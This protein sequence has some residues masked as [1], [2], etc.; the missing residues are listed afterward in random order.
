MFNQL[1]RW[2]FYFI[3][4]FFVITL[5]FSKDLLAQE[6]QSTSS[7][8]RPKIGLALSGGGAR[9]M[10]HVGVL[11]AL[12]KLRVPIDYIA[13]TSMG[14]I[15]GGLYASGVTVEELHRAAIE[16]INW[17]GILSTS[18]DLETLSYREKQNRRRFLL[19]LEMG[20]GRGQIT[21]PSGWIGGHTLFLELKRFTN[22]I[23]TDDFSQLP[24]PF[25]AVATDLKT[26]KPYLIEKGDLALALRASMAVPFIFSPVEM[27]GHVLVDGGILENLPVNAVKEMGAEIIIAINVSAPLSEI[28]SG[29]SFFQI[30]RQSID[31][32]LIQ[33]TRQALEHA[34]IVITPELEG[35]SSTNFTDGEKLITQGYEAVKKKKILFQNLSLSPE[36]YA[37]YRARIQARIPERTHT[38]KPDFV[39]FDGYQRTNPKILTKTVGNLVK[40]QV[41]IEE[42]ERVTKR[43]MSFN[44]FEHVT[45]DIESNELGETG[46]IFNIREKAWGPDYFRFGINAATTLEGK[47]NVNVLVRHEK[48]NI[49]S[50]GAEWINE[51]EFGT[52]FTFLTEF[53]QPLDYSRDY[54][55]APYAQ[56]QRQFNDVFR[57]QT[58]I[59]E[60]DI[61]RLQFGINVGKNFSN[62]AVLRMGLRS[63]TEEAR[64]RVGD[65]TLPTGNFQENAFTLEFGY[66]SL[67]DRVFATRGI[68][69]SLA[70]QIHSNLFGS[71][72][73]Y[74]KMELYTRQHAKFT[75]NF[76]FVSEI[77]LGT[78]F[79]STPPEY[80]S[81]SINRIG[82]LGGL[83]GF[84]Q[85]DIGGRQTLLMSVGGLFNPQALMQFGES[86][87]RL[88][89]MLHAG[90][91]WND[92]QD[93]NF[94]E[95]HYGSLGA[96]VW[97]TQF[98]TIQ[99]GAGY[100]NEGS[101][102]YSLS[103]G[104]FF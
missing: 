26:A 97:D 29:S 92:Y 42:I 39:K 47:A 63:S 15:V 41:S 27:D 76:T 24:I 79:Q 7:A 90:N 93:I 77:N 16:G 94:S 30:S 82:G 1:S 78:F 43:L 48:L 25:K 46:L 96:L 81:F 68:R 49:N 71:D 99:L 61:K 50:L 85:G 13:G 51:L 74:Q 37:Q 69:I 33:N 14:S 58:A 104:N 80:E 62:I 72:S 88:L 103:L 20:I 34:D 86:K 66:D 17:Q 5:Y 87:V 70:A 52:G 75:P 53:Y 100:T 23:Q 83:G 8:S 89:A 10:A 19:N 101:L 28:E 57:E 91:A 64:V 102:R 84:T 31:A 18:E 65:P 36:A 59:A 11:K 56:F 9:G 2:G 45:Y 4:L 67:D 32:A 54:F 73:Q 60:Y 98:G 21:V 40:Q 55:I 35:H 3:T 12:E 38:L 44:D 22:G 6:T 95:L